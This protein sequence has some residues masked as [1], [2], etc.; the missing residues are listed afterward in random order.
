[1]PILT[2]FIVWLVF[3]SIVGAGKAAIPALIVAV[4]MLYVSLRSKTRNLANQ[5]DMLRRELDGTTKKTSDSATQPADQLYTQK[6]PH[7]TTSSPLS[8][9]TPASTEDL[10]LTDDPLDFNEPLQSPEKQSADAEAE[11]SAQSNILP[12]AFSTAKDHLIEG[13]VFEDRNSHTRNQDNILNDL[14]DH[15]ISA[16]KRYFTDGNLFVRIGILILFAGLA[17]LIKYAAEN[18]T[19]PIEYRISAIILFGIAVLAFGWRLRERKRIYALLLQGCGTG[20]LYLAFFS[21]FK[22]YEL[23]PPTFTFAMLVVLAVTSAMLA[24]LQ[25]SRALAAFGITGGFIA[26]ILASTGSGNYIALFSYYLILNLGVVS[27]AWFKTWRIINMLGFTFTYLVFIAWVFSSYET[28]FLTTSDPFLIVYFLLFSL[29]SVLYALRQPI[30][31]KGY[32][33]SSLVFGN[34]LIVWSLHMFM[35]QHVKYGIAISAFLFGFYH[36]SLAR[37][38]WNKH[39]DGMRFYAETLL[40]IGVIFLTLAVP[41][42]LD[43]HWT[44][45]TWALEGAGILWVA[46]RQHRTLAQ[47]FA[48]ALQIGAAVV[49]FLHNDGSYDARPVINANF[50]GG[51]FIAASGFFSAWLLYREHGDG[52]DTSLTKSNVIIYLWALIWWMASGINEIVDHVEMVNRS[53]ILLLFITFSSA[54]AWYLSRWLN[55]QTAKDTSVVAIPAIIFVGIV[56]LIDLFHPINTLGV[57]TWAVT[58]SWSF[59]LLRQLEIHSEKETVVAWLHL[60]LILF[61]TLLLT[62]ELRWQLN[63]LLTSTGVAWKGIYWMVI[64]LLLL[65]HVKGAKH[66]P[67]SSYQPQLQR[68]LGIA[69]IAIS[70]F[71]SIVINYRNNGDANP[72]PY[73]PFIN[74]I[75]ITHMIMVILSYKFWRL[76]VNNDP[77]Y[78]NYRAVFFSALGIILFIWIN[79]VQLRT[80]HQYFDITFKLKYMLHDLGVQASLSILWTVMGMLAMLFAAKKHLRNLWISGAVLVGIVL[81]KMITVDLS[82]SGT[83]ERIVSFMAVGI[84]LV[85]MGYFSPI[86]EEDESNEDTKSA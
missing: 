4:V 2:G 24:I 82:A 74:P 44:S 67:F 86:P 10:S 41:Y 27:I 30:E 52:I 32:V 21:A 36:V 49:F 59:W 28:S 71:W 39:H 61:L 84:L 48:I 13:N 80:I 57:L 19:V 85:G 7:K 20:I 16:V 78:S 22:I 8:T 46:L 77:R 42:S 1:M 73:L 54:A 17:F 58:A 33:D 70:F 9:D 29:A 15:I 34:P 56:S 66:W 25:D 47:Y 75:D 18:T 53:N 31:L 62:I 26:P 83:V 12:Q 63:H 38:L 51:M 45:A 23:I 64:P 43:G 69:L 50:L 72:L 3:A 76:W 81:I 37:Y 79:A 14:P 68:E 5:L 6:T 60:A 55:W 35:I 11:H 65:W 40:S